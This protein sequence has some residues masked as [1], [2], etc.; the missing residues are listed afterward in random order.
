MGDAA[1]VGPGGVSR[2][3]APLWTPEKVGGSNDR[4]RGSVCAGCPPKAMWP[5]VIT[6]VK[7]ASGS[8]D[9]WAAMSSRRNSPSTARVTLA[10]LRVRCE[11]LESVLRQALSSRSAARAE[12][13][14]A[15][16]RLRSAGDDFV[17]AFEAIDARTEAAVAAAELRGLLCNDL[18]I[19]TMLTVA[20][21]HLLARVRPANV[22]IWLCNSR[23]DYAV[24]AYGAN[25]VSRARAEA[26]LGVLGRE[27][28]P[29]L[30]NE[31]VASVFD[32]ATEMVTVP[33]PGGGIL[34]GSRAIIAPLVFRG[35]R[36]GAVLVFQ[37]AS[38]AWQ[39]NAP[40]IVASIGAV[41]GEQIERIT[42]IVVQRGTAWPSSPSDHD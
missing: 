22:A 15:R 2:R 39:P 16:A 14:S 5:I 34:A 23:G 38:E 18:D 42:R 41:L 17:V 11:R 36:F 26:S 19:D 10:D 29:H 25:S 12:R 31:P 35:E 40:E 1:R 28:C 7:G 21:E 27:A 32:T 9:A 6:V 3:L 33:P 20:T 13:D 8:A 37:P 4:H 30:G 24:A